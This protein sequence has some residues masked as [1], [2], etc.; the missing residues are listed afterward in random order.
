M[1]GRGGDDSRTGR[2]LSL[3]LSLSLSLKKVLGREAALVAPAVLVSAWAGCC[4]WG[5]YVAARLG[6]YGV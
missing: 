3:S 5:R 1:E 6:L 2:G 4:C